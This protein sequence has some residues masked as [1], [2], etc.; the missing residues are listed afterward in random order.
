MLELCFD[1]VNS[2]FD[3]L[4]LTIDSNP[5]PYRIENNK[6]VI[7]DNIE[8]GIHILRLQLTKDCNKLTI[9]DVYVDGVGL[10]SSLY[11]SYLDTQ[12]IKTQPATSLWTTD[13]VWVLPFGNP[14]SQW[15]TT[16]TNKIGL[17]KLGTDLY[18]LYNIYYPEPVVLPDSFPK[19]VRDFFYYDFDF[20]VVEKS[21]ISSQTI[22][23]YTIDADQ[24]LMD[25][26]YAEILENLDWFRERTYR[27]PQVDYNK[28]DTASLE[29]DHW[30][31][32]SYI[33]KN[34]ETGQFEIQFDQAKFPALA[35]L[36][37]SFKLTEQTRGLIAITKPNSFAAPHMD[38]I[39]ENAADDDWGCCQIYIP[40]IKDSM[41]KL[42]GVGVLPDQP[43]IINNVRYMHAIANN[44]Q[45]LRVALTL[46]ATTSKNR[47]IYK[48]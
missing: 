16:V 46:K 2:K 38:P 22:P 10:R 39:R 15:L 14:V 32:F 34:S 13:Q 33:E 36:I 1:A 45:S 19:L 30:A 40:L 11:L 27:P 37:S 41:I 48:F 25:E 23:F 24:T 44:T 20:T 21:N 42:A 8:F 43:M 18:K 17:S 6:I 3:S 12:G 7:N 9:T 5:V 35:R 31:I 29:D 47:H 26:A 28:K 4:I